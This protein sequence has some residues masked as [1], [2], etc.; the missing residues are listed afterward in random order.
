[1]AFRLAIRGT[2]VH[3]DG[4]HA[5]LRVLVARYVDAASMRLPIRKI[6][7]RLAGISIFRA[8]GHITH[9]TGPAVEGGVRRRACRGASL[10]VTCNGHVTR[11]GL[12]FR[13]RRGGRARETVF[14]AHGRRVAAPRLAVR[15]RE[16]DF[17]GPSAA[18][19]IMGDDH[20]ARC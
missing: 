16:V 8:L 19:A 20:V 17:P 9:G 12:T 6:A 13:I 15:P 1:M 3:V 5:G 10:L 2:A 7:H 4:L 18:L 11:G 14:S